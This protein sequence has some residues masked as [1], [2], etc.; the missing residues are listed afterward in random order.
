MSEK[1]IEPKRK[2][3]DDE[4]KLMKAVDDNREQIIK[5]LTTLIEYD[6]RTF[7][8]KTYSDLSAVFK[9][10]EDWFVENGF[11][12]SLYDCPWPFKE[13]GVDK[14]W[15]NLIT[16]C[17][18]SDDG[19][20]LQFNGHLDVVDFNPKKWRDQ[21]QPLKAEIR[22]DK[23]FGRGSLDM[24]GGVSCQ[25][26]AMKILKDLD[27]PLSG[28]L[29]M[30]LAPDEEIDGHYGAQ[31]MVDEHLDIVESDAT[32]ISE[33]TRQE[34]IQSPAIIVGEKGTQ[35]FKMT[36]YGSAGHGSMPKPKSNAISKAARFIAEQKKL[37]MPKAS[38]P[39]GYI[40]MIKGLLS[41]FKLRDIFGMITGTEE[42]DPDP[43]DEDGLPVAG[44]FNTTFGVNQIQAGSQVN[45]IPD[46]CQLKIDCRVLPGVNTQD[47][48]DSFADYMTKLGYRIEF[49]DP[50]TNSQSS[51]S[52]IMERPVDAR[53]EIISN[54]PG[55][56]VEPEGNKYV[57]ILADSFEN[58]FR[59]NAVYFF[60]PGS[61]DGTH[62]R[63]AGMKNVIVFGPGG[64]NAHSANEFVFVEDLIRCTKVY[65]L[66]AYRLL[67]PEE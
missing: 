26:M 52:K 28:S 56:F 60:A 59:T 6:S 63:K 45:V 17:K 66:T 20:K 49:P 3:N 4:K 35:W 55:T 23:L 64:G 50:Y 7:N 46:K 11:D 12:V 44:L 32:I 29:Q 8:F 38:P 27:I 31:Y 5:L 39:I 47:I 37:K 43:Y 19:P 54:D 14:F 16:E 51:N 22:G 30:W 24:K 48:F 65:L 33:G 53:I 15:P 61:T 67:K 42:T 21:L 36:F 18:F 10:A 34:P 1:I 58:I 25:M 41:R 13:D 2:L 40:G 9:Y 62:M 57:E